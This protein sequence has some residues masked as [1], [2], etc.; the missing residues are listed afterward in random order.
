VNVFKF[1]F[2]IVCRSREFQ[3]AKKGNV[4]ATSFGSYPEIVLVIEKN[5]IAVIGVQRKGIVLFLI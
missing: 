5:N 2:V 1:G 4:D 3:G